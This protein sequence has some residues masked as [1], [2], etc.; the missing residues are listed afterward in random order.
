MKH[1]SSCGYA[2][3]VEWAV[4]GQLLC[5]ISVCLLIGGRVGESTFVWKMNAGQELRG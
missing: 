2:D 3:A 4:T 5:D 1:C